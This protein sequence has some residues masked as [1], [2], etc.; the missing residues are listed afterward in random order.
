MTAARAPHA[1][2]AFSGLRLRLW[3]ILLAAL[4]MQLCLVPAREL[5]RWLFLEVGPAG[6][7]DDLGMLV[8]TAIMLQGL[9][10][11]LGIAV[12]GRLLPRADA[13]LRW[14]PGR[15]MVGLAA[16]IGVVM[17]LVML[18]ADHWPALLAG[19]APDGGY[20]LDP[21]IVA[22]WLLAMI[23][24][25]LG[26][27]T[28]FRGLLVGMLVVLVP[29]RV[30]AGRFEVPVAGVIVAL[31]FG[32]AHYESFQYHPLHQAIAQQIYAFAWGLVYVWLMEQSRSLLAP[33]VA[34]GVGNFVEVALV[35]ALMWARG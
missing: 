20:S 35:M 3:P 24:T 12:M 14:P 21:P 2:L 29:G 6:W 23:T 5:V 1:F 30:R 16:A 25:G 28:V 34:H 22:G 15:S 9:C 31:L 4:I 13:H 17:G 11:L 8:F 33:I 10:G 19:V 27:E 18:V 26:E 7:A 32:V